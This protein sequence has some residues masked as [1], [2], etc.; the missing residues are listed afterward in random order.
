LKTTQILTEIDSEGEYITISLWDRGT[1]IYK[2]RRKNSTN[3]K[4]KNIKFHLFHLNRIAKYNF[5]KLMGIDAVHFG[6]VFLYK[7]GFRIA[8]YGDIGFDYFG[9]DTRKAQKHFN[10]LGTRDLIGRIELVGDNIHFREISSRDG[11]LVRNEHY[12]EM[13]NCF[14]QNCLVK[15]ENYLNNVQ[16]TS[17]EDKDREDLQALNTIR[18][19]SALLDLIANESDEKDAELLD[20]DKENLSIRTE[21]LLKEAS[22]QDIDTLRTIAYKLGDRTFEKDTEKIKNEY[23]ILEE[24]LK[25]EE[26]ERKRIEEELEAEKKKL[27][28]ELEAERK[29][30]LFNKKLVG[31]EIKEVINLQHHIDRATDKIDDNVDKLIHGIND[32]ASKTSLLRYVE[33]ISLESKKISSIAQFVTNANFNVKVKRISRDINRF[34]REY[35]ENVHQEYEHLKLNRKLLNVLIKTD[36][37]QF[38]MQF[39]P[40]EVIIIIDNLFSN[41]FKAKAKNVLVTLRTKND[42]VFE[43]KF[44][45]DGK[46]IQDNVLPRIFNLGFTT[47]DG[48]SGIGLF[49]IKTIT[50]KMDGE[51]TVNNKLEKGVEFKILFKR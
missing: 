49:H 28:E 5:K 10:K 6:S 8:P 25:K 34:I 16:W 42:N 45:D 37:K 46:G 2:I 21:E 38:I 47:T 17:N 19:K 3:P 43:M 44:E 4:L 39:I 48:G 40:I 1:L 50:D 11:G 12:H 33:K 29:E 22:E 23:K 14:I 30:S 18:A 27:E 36:E 51:I 20:A 7:N 41:A 26:T 15:L 9:L 31:T 35:I 13:V 32:D 24:R